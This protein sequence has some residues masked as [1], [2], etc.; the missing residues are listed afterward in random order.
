M[1]PRTLANSHEQLLMPSCPPRGPFRAPH[2]DDCH[3]RHAP[4]APHPRAHLPC[5][6]SRASLYAPAC[7]HTT[8]SATDP[9]PMTCRP[10][11]PA[12][13]DRP[14][15]C[16]CPTS[17]R[18][19]LSEACPPACRLTLI[20]KLCP[21]PLRKTSAQPFPVRSDEGRTGPRPNPL[22]AHPTLHAP[23]RRSTPI[24]GRA[25]LPASLP[26]VTNII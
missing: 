21:M 18:A 16:P 17:S 14:C 13:P 23:R 8:Q 6:S 5:A 9:L 19:S 24:D 20:H 2:R 12:T 4:A 1:S 25:S 3:R 11:P 7:T 15:P 10:G 22:A 26:H